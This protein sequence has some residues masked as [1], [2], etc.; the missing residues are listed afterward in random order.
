MR[1]PGERRTGPRALPGRWALSGEGLLAGLPRQGSS[2]PPPDSCIFSQLRV[3]SSIQ[4]AGETA[5]SDKV[6]DDLGTE[7]VVDRLI[8]ASLHTFSF[9]FFP[10]L[11]LCPALPLLPPPTFG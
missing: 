8:L 10:D 1:G 5:H 4:N 6:L 3:I 11:T 2:F 7:V 9:L